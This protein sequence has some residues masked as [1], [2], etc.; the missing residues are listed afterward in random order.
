MHTL[1]T[2]LQNA[3]DDISKCATSQGLTSLSS[4][5]Y[6]VI[7]SKKDRPPPQCLF[8]LNGQP[9]PNLQEMKLLDMFLTENEHGIIT[10]I[11]SR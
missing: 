9:I 10:K 1:S 4:E 7:F 5:T 6:Y 2:T 8:K 3:I 11:N